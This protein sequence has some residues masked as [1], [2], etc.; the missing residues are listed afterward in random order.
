MAI[1]EWSRLYSYS[2]LRSIENTDL[3]LFYSKISDF[4]WIYA[5]ALE[6]SK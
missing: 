3:D 1:P 6:A 4:L 5:S 2:G